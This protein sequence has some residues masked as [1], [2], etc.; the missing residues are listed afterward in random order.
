MYVISESRV[1]LKAVLA[2]VVLSVTTSYAAAWSAG[3]HR[4]VANIAYDLLDDDTKAKVIKIL[5]KHPHIHQNEFR[6]TD[7]MADANQADKDRWIFLQA[8]IWP[9]LLNNGSSFDID[10]WHFINEPFYL[11]PLDEQALKNLPGIVPDKSV[12]NQ[13]PTTD[14]KN[15]N[16]VQAIKLCMA[17]LQDPNISDEKKAVYI[18]WLIH[19]IGDSHQ[20]LH[21][22][23]LYSRGRFFELTGDRGGNR[24]PTKQGGNLHSFWDGLLGKKQ[25]L[26]SIRQRSQ[27]IVGDMVLKKAGEDAAI[28]LAPEK[29]IEESHKITTEFVYIKEI[30]DEVT[31]KEANP[32]QPLAKVDL[33][34]AYR[35]EAGRI[36]Q[37]RVSEAGHRLAEMIKKA[38]Q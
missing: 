26:N 25:T 20:P 29:W 19:M 31:N 9:D 17:R 35:T 28:E 15:Y 8:S 2:L 5:K 12:P 10:K 38:I 4:T 3:G 32:Q 13:F 1:S 24:I 22:T 11:S 27:Q 14:P 21:S 18:C 33:P 34:L 30:L 6:F 7:D 37:Q 16:C 36:A 23:S